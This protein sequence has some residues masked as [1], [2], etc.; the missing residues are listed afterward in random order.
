[1][2]E[3]IEQ[4]PWP[5]FQDFWDLYD[6]KR[7]KPKAIFYWD[8][9]TQKEKEE[10][11]NYIPLY[12]ESQPNKLYRKDPERFLRYKCFEDELIPRTNERQLTPT[13]QRKSDLLSSL[14]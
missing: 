9:L 5:T 14:A 12:I 3:Q 10:C 6:K 13:E 8:K 1:M 7:G 2:T 4:M 11:M